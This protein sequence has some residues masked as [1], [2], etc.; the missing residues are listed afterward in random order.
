MVILCHVYFTTIKKN[1]RILN[2]LK[3]DYRYMGIHYTLL[4]TSKLNLSKIK[5]FLRKKK[6]KKNTQ[7]AKQPCES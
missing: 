3:L 4:T 7:N 1:G 6:K 5:V 2:I